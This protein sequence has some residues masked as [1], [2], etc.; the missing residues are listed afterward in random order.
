MKYF[1]GLSGLSPEVPEKIQNFLDMIHL[2]RDKAKELSVADLID[3]IAETSGYKEYILDG[4]P[5]G[6]G[7]YENIYV[8]PE[9][10]QHLRSGLSAD[11]SSDEPVFLKKAVV[12]SYP[13]LGNGISKKDYRLISVCTG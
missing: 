2:I 12:I 1:S 9:T 11:S 13:V 3:L 4:T 6:E 8:L 7:R 5:E 10:H